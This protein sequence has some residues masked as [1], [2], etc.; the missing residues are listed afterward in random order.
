MLPV[1]TRNTYLLAAELDIPI[2]VVKFEE[3]VWRRGV[4]RTH[5]LPDQVGAEVLEF[6]GH[7]GGGWGTVGGVG[8]GEV[9]AIVLVVDRFGGREFEVLAENEALRKQPMGKEKSS[10]GHVRRFKT[11]VFRSIFFPALFAVTRSMAVLGTS[12][13]IASPWISISQTRGAAQQGARRTDG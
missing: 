13:A 11:I 3:L 12:S 4:R 1:H 5:D 7:F 2:E 8:G 9:V 6:S 10:T